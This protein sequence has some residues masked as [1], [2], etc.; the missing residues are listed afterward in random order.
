M[1][2]QKQLSLVRLFGLLRPASFPILIRASGFETHGGCVQLLDK[3]WC[4]N[5]SLL[6]RQLTCGVMGGHNTVTNTLS[7]DMS[8]YMY[9]LLLVLV[10]I[11]PNM[12]LSQNEGIDN[13]S[14]VATPSQLEEAYQSHY[15]R[16]DS[17]GEPQRESASFNRTVR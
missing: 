8:Y 4:L 13:A 14:A 17:I 16:T 6:S 3:Q 10:R 2:S 7:H 5:F 11:F 1:A 15:Y 12:L 9:G